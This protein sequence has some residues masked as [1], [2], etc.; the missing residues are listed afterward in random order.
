MSFRF[1]IFSTVKIYHGN[2]LRK[3]YTPLCLLRDE[4]FYK[5]SLFLT[6]E[7]PV[8]IIA[9]QLFRSILTDFSLRTFFCNRQNVSQWFCFKNFILWISWYTYTVFFILCDLCDKFTH[10]MTKVSS[11]AEMYFSSKVYDTHFLR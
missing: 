6:T 10:T 7:I 9:R 11:I 2:H 1:S 8:K 4:I 3:Y 5:F